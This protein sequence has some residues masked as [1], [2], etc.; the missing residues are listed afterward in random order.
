[1]KG[2]IVILSMIFAVNANAQL[3]TT[4]PNFITE[5]SSA[6]IITAD[7]NKGNKGLKGFTGDV[8]VHIGVITNLSV[9]GS[10]TNWW[11]Y[12]TSVWNSPVVKF[13]CVNLGNDKFSYTI[14]DNLRSFFGIT[15]A[16][17]KI[18]KV[19]ILFKDATG[20][21]ALRN[22]DATDMFVNVYSNA[23]SVRIDTPLAQPLYAPLIEPIN[24]KVGDTLFMNAKAN[25]SAVLSLYYNDTLVSA[26]NNATSLSAFKIINKEGTQKVL[27]KAVLNSETIKD[28]INFLV[29]GNIVVENLPAGITDGINYEVGD[30]SAYLVL[31]APKKLMVNVI[32]D[33]NA[34]TASLPYLMKMTPDSARFWI[35][36]KGLTP[37]V[38]YAYQYLIDGTITVA[39][40]NAEKVLDPDNDAA[41]PSETYPN[42]KAYPLGK[43]TGIVS[44]LQTAKPKYAWKVTNFNRPNKK[45]L[46]IYEVLLRDFLQKHNYNSLRDTIPYLKKLGINTIELMPVSE[47]EGNDSWGYNGNFYFALDKYYGTEMAFREFV[48]SAHAQGI[49]VVIDMVMNHTFGSSPLALMYWDGKNNYPAADNPWLNQAAKHPFNVGNDLNHESAATKQLVSRVVKHWLTQYHIDGFRWDM[50][51]GFTQKNNPTDVAA[52]GLYDASRIAIW[53]N[54]YDTMQKVSTNSYCIL[55][56]FADNTEEKELADYGMLLWGNANYNFNQATMGYSTDAS[57]NGAFANGRTWNQ[58]HLVTYM[59]SHDEERLMYKNLN[60]GNLNGS[61]STKDLNTGLKRNEMAAAFWALTPGPKLMWQFGELGYDYSINTCTDL[62]TN[63]NCRLSQKPIKWDYSNNA[64]R[65]GLYNAYAQFLQLRNNPKYLNDFISNKYSLNTVG[66]VKSIQLN[67]DSIKLVIVGNFDVTQQSVSVSFPSDGIWYSTFTS[68]YITVSN[69]LANITLLPGEYYVYANKNISTQMITG[70]LNLSLPILEMPVSVYP[71]PITTSTVLTY[72]L[73]ESGNLSLHIYDLNGSDCGSIFSGYQFKGFQK[74][75][76]KKNE[77]MQNPGIYF[78]SI[79]LNQKQKVQK[80]LITN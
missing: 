53:K 55:E 59:E 63:N 80:I 31:Y 14:N 70:I 54:I 43:T 30:T 32:G 36:L 29:A 73:P 50:S 68:K 61:Y 39:D 23:L 71:N 62:T 44:V 75:A 19:A 65:K 78:L 41:I 67:G 22:T 8:Y 20:S 6:T 12:V 48:D 5:S 4:T 28:S 27:A 69:G 52:W 38:E 33:F 2:L 79:L 60:Y 45:N 74:I 9:P 16:N 47:F 37:G 11:R 7:A 76:L 1:M 35:R 13:K 64:S 3:L 26:V 15:D 66:L 49:A 46:I 24:K 77:R 17:E 56:H 58:Q 25:T 10:T 51:K 42:L 21:K 40:Y 34:W 57:L 72:N 18:L